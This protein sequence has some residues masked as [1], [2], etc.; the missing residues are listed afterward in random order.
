MSYFSQ[1]TQLAFHNFVSGAVGMAIAVAVARA[2]KLGNFWQDL[3]RGTLYELDDIEDVVDRLSE[4]LAAANR[5]RVAAVGAS[6]S[7]RSERAELIVKTVA[8]ME[9]ELE[10]IRLPLHILLENHFGDLN[11]NQEEMLG[12]ARTAA[13]AADAQL[14]RL[15]RIAA[16]GLGNL[17]LRRDPI[18]IADD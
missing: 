18:R 10:Q 17:P 7:R 9:R 1:M 14:E 8:G 12:A 5:S 11:E 2:G 4:S 16:L 13:E 15:K 3:V 6:E